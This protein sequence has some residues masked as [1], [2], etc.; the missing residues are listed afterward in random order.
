MRS[1]VWMAWM[2]LLLTVLGSPV[3]ARREAAVQA[4]AGAG[5]STA[6]AVLQLRP[7]FFMIAGAGGNIGVQIGDDGVVVVDAGSASSA[8]AVVAAIKGL[9][10]RPIRYVINTGADPDH[11]GGNATVSRAGRDA[12]HRRR[13]PRD[14][15]RF[16]GGAASILSSEKV[17]ARM[18]A[19]SGAAPAFPAAGWPTETFHQ[20]RKY[21]YLNGEG[22]EV[23]HQPAAHS[24]GDAIVFFRRSDVI[25][26]RGRAGHDALPGHRRRARRQHRRGDRGAQS[27]RGPRHSVGA[28]RVARRGHARHSRTRSRVRPARRRRVPRH[29]DHR[30]RPRAR[31]D[32]GRL[33]AGP[34]QGGGAGARLHAAVWFRHGA[35]DDQ[36]LRGSRVS[37]P[38]RGRSHERP[39]A[40]RSPCWAPCSRVRRATRRRQAR[41][42]G[43]PPTPRA[44]AAIDLTGYWVSASPR[45]GR[46]A[47]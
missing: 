23:L 45:T 26:A 16:I 39:P 21:M 11:V 32:T 36:R 4:A 30:A 14:I 47:C 29:G 5:Q 40:L 18:S 44:A 15:G 13:R 46:S 9:S 3:A 41:G 43:P 6:P 31:S 19:P 17:L 28:D 34:G 35:V 10:P 12:L 8:D 22:I 38:V 25:V 33:V 2:A 42:G 1:A 37:E 24:D 20:P 27:P 7:N